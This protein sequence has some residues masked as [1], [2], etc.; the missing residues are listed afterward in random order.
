MN[1]PKEDNI[2]NDDDYNDGWQ[3]MGIFKWNVIHACG[4]VFFH[5]QRRP[6]SVKG[7]GM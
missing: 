5:M 2:R 3:R 7:Q 4:M 6:V 1:Y